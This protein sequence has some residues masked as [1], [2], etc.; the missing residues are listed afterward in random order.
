MTTNPFLKQ[1]VE[2]IQL[3]KSMVHESGEMKDPAL[4]R[5]VNLLNV[6][7]HRTA[8]LVSILVLIPEMAGGLVT[9]AIM[10]SAN[11]PNLRT[12]GLVNI[13]YV[14]ILLCTFIYLEVHSFVSKNSESKAYVKNYFSYLANYRFATD[15]L[16]K[17][18]PVVFILAIGRPEYLSSL[19]VLYIA[20]Y[21][22][23][24][25]FFKVSRNKSI[26]LGVTCLLIAISMAVG[27]CAE[28][29]IPA[30][31]FFSIT[32]LSLCCLKAEYIELKEMA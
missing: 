11:M 10:A 28:I 23:Q 20:E 31:L 5:K 18:L 22:F 12:Y 27:G 24:G 2:D 7:L 13:L 8:L 3:I 19:F 16:I 4:K 17:F 15:L 26:L 6:Q 21:L 14:L 1:A 29:L 25:R 30:L 9:N 32:V